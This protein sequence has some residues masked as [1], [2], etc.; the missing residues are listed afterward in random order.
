MSTSVLLQADNLIALPEGYV[1]EPS[2]DIPPLDGTFLDQLVAD[3]VEIEL[4]ETSSSV[5]EF[6]LRVYIGGS[7][8]PLGEILPILQS[9]GLDVLEEH[10]MVL[11]RTDGLRCLV[12]DFRLRASARLR[13]HL[14]TGPA[15]DVWRSRFVDAFHGARDHRLELDDL[16]ALVIACGM[17][18]HEVAVLRAYT[19]YLRQIGF[20]HSSGRIASALIEHPEITE[21]L[22]AAFEARFSPTLPPAPEAG[23]DDLLREVADLDADRIL[24][25]LHGLIGAT[26]RTSYYRNTDHGYLTL[27]LSPREIDDVPQPAPL[28]ETFVYSPAFEGTHL[29]FG[30]VARGGLR[31]S[32]REDFRTEI[33]GL[34]KAQ[35]VKNAVIVP[36]GAKGGF[37]VKSAAA[38]VLGTADT[39]IA[40]YRMFIAGLLDITDNVATDGEIL[41]PTDVRRHDDPDPYLVVAADKGTARF[42]DTANDVAA[43]Y[44]FWLGDAF[45]SGGSR[46]YDHKAMGITARGA[47]ESVRRHFA[48]GGLDVDTDPVTVTGIGDMSGDVFG[49]GMLSSPAIRLVAAFDHRHIFIDPDPDAAQGFAERRRL[50]DLERSSWADYDTTT[51]SAGGGVWSRDAKSIPVSAPM[52]TALGL[53]NRSSLTP[54]E[55][56]RHILC[57]PV[58]LLWNGGIGTYIKASDESHVQVGDKTNDTVRVDATRVRARVIGEGGNLGVTSPGRIEFALA[59]GRI[60][61]DAMDNSAG[62]DC[63]D[64]EVNIKILLG[65][66]LRE[67]AITSIERDDLLLAMTDAVAET[68]LANNISQNRLLGAARHTAASRLDAHARLIEILEA[69]RGLD[70]ALEALP[71]TDEIARRRHDRIGLSSP[72]LATL[73]AHVK[74]AYKAQVEP[75]SLPDS[76]VMEAELRQYF[77]NLLREPFGDAVAEHRLRREIIANQIVNEMVDNAGITYA[78]RLGEETGADVVDATKAYKVAVE[79]FDL[80]GLWRAIREAGLDPAIEYD[81]IVESRRLV[82]R[83]ARWFLT[84]RPQPLAIGAEIARFATA[85]QTLTPLVGA[86]LRGS[87]AAA[88]NDAALRWQDRGVPATIATPVSELLYWYSA[89]DII[90]VAEQTGCASAEVAEVYFALSER[91]SVDEFLLAISQLPKNSRWP[92]MARLSLRDDLY[93]AL[94]AITRTVVAAGNGELAA[95][96]AITE[97]EQDHAARLNRVRPILGSLRD[98]ELDITAL[99]VAVRQLRGLVR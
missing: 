44:D 68:V 1:V 30:S 42:S 14:D 34:V 47:W 76:P 78:F 32:D 8:L 9:F 67:G 80:T 2:R 91:L 54:D 74:L 49:N 61:T 28:I 82:D 3:R 88:A 10:P 64:H 41:A 90:D 73:A 20:G 26:T 7:E 87:E 81:L 23:I 13:R 6:G 98:C 86:L 71:D 66:L 38:A 45:A 16:N 89:L 85:V 69:D 27:K 84:H 46:G 43:H 95:A 48:E 12:Y 22:F 72:E 21:T 51:I 65:A 97:W 11:R 18:W 35:A 39:G 15:A 50:F 70:R 77:P 55:L 92:T 33:L 58:D 59:G 99:A 93:G 24:R 62:V 63:S 60:N 37:V 19:R 79:V 94:R 36:A 56:I 31:W 53:P 17:H 83:A 96:T 4:L 40:C 25:T 57:A 29:R 52:A 5:D 75:S